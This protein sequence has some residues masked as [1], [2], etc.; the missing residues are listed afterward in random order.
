MGIRL[1]LKCR[2]NNA[3]R[4]PRIWMSV[5][6]KKGGTTSINQ[7]T[8]YQ[9]KSTYH[10]Y[11]IS[12]NNWFRVHKM[13]LY[14]ENQIISKALSWNQIILSFLSWAFC[15]LPFNSQISLSSTAPT[16]NIPETYPN[17]P[18]SYIPE[19]Q[20]EHASFTILQFSQH[21]NHHGEFWQKNCPSRVQK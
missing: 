20:I 13:L 6:K 14:A 5:V 9:L 21:C 10:I 18:N 4:A 17:I 8:I 3:Q 19:T 1:R 11:Y 7:D 12:C 2:V 16:L 15:R